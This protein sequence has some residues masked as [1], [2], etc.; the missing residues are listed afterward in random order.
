MA[1]DCLL[2]ITYTKSAIGYSQRQKDTIRAM[3]LRRLGDSVIQPDNAAMRGMIQAVSHL[4][5]VAPVVDAAGVA[6]N[7]EEGTAR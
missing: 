7:Q 2:Q 4:V 3:G 6:G 1:S 5:A